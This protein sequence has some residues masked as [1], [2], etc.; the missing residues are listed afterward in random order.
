MPR[1]TKRGIWCGSSEAGKTQE[2]VAEYVER[3]HQ[4]GFNLLLVH[5]KGGDGRVWWPSKRFKDL[6]QPGYEEF[7]LPA[8]L[9]AECRKRGMELHAWFIDYMDGQRTYQEHPE[10][11]VRNAAG[12]P[13]NSEVLRGKP[14]DAVWMC[15]AQ[16]PGYT[17]QRLVPLYEEFAEMYDFDAIHHDYI[18]YP[19]DLAPDQYCFCDYCLENLPKWAGYVTEAFP[20][21]PF[22]HELYDRE[23]LEA[24]WEQSPRVLPANWDRL[25]RATKSRFL[26]E[27]SFFQGGRYDLDYFFYAYRV[28]WVREFARLC[29]EAVNRTRPGMKISAAVFK[30][31]IHSGRFIGQDW[32][33]FAGYVDH[34]LPMDYRDHYPGSFETY[35][36]LLAESIHQQKEW[37]RDFEAFWPG[38]AINFLYR[39]EEQAGAKT[40]SPEKFERVVETI[41]STGV[42]GMIVFCEGHLHQFDLW[43]AAQ[44][45]FR[46]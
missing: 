29:R 15:P 13:T 45:L 11:A 17:D 34:M 3:M 35:L 19:G 14:F 22:Y 12:L 32:R 43:D 26:L 30:N 6:I 25:P 16:R 18:R 39:E 20:E 5:L 36:T 28:H 33:T 44:S 7:D 40:F 2:S 46:D 42:E 24:H 38:I 21:E 8:A 31:P 9:L 41:H 4:A 37:A 23:Y 10:W 27:G 1:F